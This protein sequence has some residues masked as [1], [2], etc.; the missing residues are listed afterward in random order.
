MLVAGQHFLEHSWL[1]GDGC[2]TN[3]LVPFLGSLLLR[4]IRARRVGQIVRVRAI[5]GR[6]IDSSVLLRLCRDVRRVR[7]HI[8]NETDLAFIR[9]LH[10]IEEL[11]RE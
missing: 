8:R 11:L 1:A 10:A 3:R 2:W 7:T 4:G 9:E 5:V 6:Y